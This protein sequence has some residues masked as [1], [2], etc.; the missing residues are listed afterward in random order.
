MKYDASTTANRV[1]NMWVDGVKETANFSYNEGGAF[2]P[3]SSAYW[4][5]GYNSRS[6]SPYTRDS[7]VD[8]GNIEFY[9]TFLSDDDVIALYNQRASIDKSNFFT[10]QLNETKHK[11]LILPYTNWTVN[12]TGSESFFGQNGSTSE[13]TRL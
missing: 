13:N 3:N 4:W 8:F 11:P 7:D 2:G 9:G 10:K 5:L 1:M 12:G 6:Y